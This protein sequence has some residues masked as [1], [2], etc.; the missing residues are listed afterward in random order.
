MRIVY[1]AIIIVC[2]MAAGLM[3]G[4]ARAA[5]LKDKHETYTHIMNNALE[6]ECMKH[7]RMREGV[8]HIGAMA[9]NVGGD[10]RAITD[11]CREMLYEAEH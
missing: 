7:V 2:S 11:K 6:R 3:L 10:A 1:L 9:A 8:E 4:L 5:W